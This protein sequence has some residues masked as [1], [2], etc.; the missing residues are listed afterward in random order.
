[1]K[2]LLP[3]NSIISV[4]YRKTIESLWLFYISDTQHAESVKPYA[5]D[6]GVNAD[7]VH[8]KKYITEIRQYSL[9]L[10][11]LIEKNG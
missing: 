8:I 1:M 6:N 10:I 7:S 2:P 5:G 11:L 9:E 3:E 4:R